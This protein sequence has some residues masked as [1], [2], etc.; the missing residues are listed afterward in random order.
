M[1]PLTYSLMWIGSLALAGI[2]IFS[3]FY[4]KDVILESA[5]AAHS[6]A[7]Q[8]AF[9]LGVLAALLTAF[10]SWRLLF[11]TFHG[12]AR[13]SHDVMHHVHESPPVMT[14]PLM[15]LG[16]GAVLAGIVFAPYFVGEHLEEFWGE[17]I[18]VLSSHTALEDAHHSP[19]LVVWAP[20]IVA[21]LGIATAY[22]FY[23][24]RPELPGRV[25]ASLRPLYLFFL[26]KWYWDELYDAIFVR[27]AMALGRALWKGGDEAT[28]DRFG[29]NGVAGRVVAI[30]RRTTRLQTGYV[31][32]YAFVMLIGV[33]AL[34]SWYLL[35]M[36]A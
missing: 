30:A 15:V 24:L 35:V 25:A 29:P 26:N 36:R 19:A 28:I 33:V 9:W 2:P 1:I 16:V 34:V 5:W 13:A 22:L 11:M 10:Y 23:V 3:G 8:F 31:Y 32:H 7:G 21:V 20:T 27:P 18:F 4:S 12:P 6:G 17:A 14:V